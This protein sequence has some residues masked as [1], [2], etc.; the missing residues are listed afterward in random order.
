MTMRLTIKNEDEHRT[1]TLQS[2]RFNPSDEA[3]SSV[4]AHQ[5]LIEIPPGKTVECWVH[6]HLK[7]VVRESKMSSSAEKK[8]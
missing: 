5:T 1:A 8:T 7:V 3:E 6:E 4:P 2:Y